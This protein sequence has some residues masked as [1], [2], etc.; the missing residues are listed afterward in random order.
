MNRDAFVLAAGFGTR[1]QPLTHHRPKA[2]VP[3]CGVPMLAYALAACGRAGLRRVLV[4]AHHLPEQLLPW[5]GE[6]EGVEVDVVVEA[7]EILGTGGGLKAVVDRLAP[8]VVVV[9]ADVLTDVDLGALREAVPP[10]GAALAL[11]PHPEDAERYG[12]VATDATQVVVRLR[13]I[14]S[15]S[16]VGEIALDTHFTGNHALDRDALALV[17]D[18]FSC[19]V[20]TAYKALVP[21]RKVIGLRHEGLWLDVGD[22]AAYLLANLTVLTTDHPLPLDPFARAACARGPRGQV[23]TPPAA[24]IAGCVWIGRDARVDGSSLRDT[25]IG[26]RATVPAGTTLTRCVVWDG[27]TVPAGVWSDTIFHD[28][29]AVAVGSTG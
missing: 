16:P 8:R 9:N 11:R 13:E 2:L 22:P 27:V 25:V 7:P 20:R 10:G 6:H 24:T 19:I 5:R 18:G 21:R 3:V 29:G 23:G 1:L 4:N 12:I 17:P 26:E 15:A 14:A 28:G